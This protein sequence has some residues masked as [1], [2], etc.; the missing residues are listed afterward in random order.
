MVDISVVQVPLAGPS[1]T[2]GF[3]KPP[4]ELAQSRSC[5]VNLFGNGLDTDAH[6]DYSVCQTFQSI[7]PA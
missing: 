6:S 3:V 1:R 5:V 7:F 2:R 4:V